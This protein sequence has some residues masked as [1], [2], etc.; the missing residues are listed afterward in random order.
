MKIVIVCLLLTLVLSQTTLVL[1]SPSTVN[2]VAPSGFFVVAE[3]YHSAVNPNY[4]GN[5]AQWIWLNGSSSW[6]DGFSATF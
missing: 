1:S 6:A 5:G 4:L 2:L 3:A